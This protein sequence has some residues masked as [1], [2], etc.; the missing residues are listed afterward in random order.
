M[1]FNISIDLLIIVDDLVELQAV[2][3]ILSWEIYD[4]HDNI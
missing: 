4:M 3:I 2:I 1:H